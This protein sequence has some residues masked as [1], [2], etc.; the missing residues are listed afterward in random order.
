MPALPPFALLSALSHRSYALLWVGQTV[1]QLGNGIHLI[2]LA[3]WVLQET[4]SAAAMGT[5]LV[6]ASVPELLLLLVGGV[7]VDRFSRPWLL[8]GADVVRGGL[9]ALVALLAWNGSLELWHV[10]VM[11]A[12]FGLADALS[13]PAH[14][15]VIA[16]LLPPDALASAN[17]LRSIS[18]QVGGIVGPAL[19]GVIVAGG[20]LSALVIALG[21]LHPAIR[22]LD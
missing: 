10:L 21:L 18:A 7:A 9:M 4:G 2:A 6:A 17:S 12:V 1:S 22:R 15:A 3:W 5:V 14:T 11:S 19:G 13:Y 8:L 16:D 20:L